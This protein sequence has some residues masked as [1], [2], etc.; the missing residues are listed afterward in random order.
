MS[1]VGLKDIVEEGEKTTT[2]AFDG[3]LYM[4]TWRWLSAEAVLR[5][6]ISALRGEVSALLTFET[7]E[8]NR[9]VGFRPIKRVQA[10]SRC[11]ISCEFI[12]SLVIYQY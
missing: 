11:Q 2:S 7:S 6:P 1:I 10:C 5:L 3:F 8:N 12:G 4:H 9:M